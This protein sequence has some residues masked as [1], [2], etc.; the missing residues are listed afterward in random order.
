[1]GNWM[2]PATDNDLNTDSGVLLIPSDNTSAH[3]AVAHRALDMSVVRA[4]LW[5][6]LLWTLPFQLCEAVNLKCTA[7]RRGNLMIYSIDHQ[8]FP[9][10]VNLSSCY[11]SWS[12]D[13]TVLASHQDKL[14]SVKTKSL[15]NLET[16]ECFTNV[17]HKSHCASKTTG[18][19]TN[20]QAKC[21]ANCSKEGHKVTAL[22]L[23]LCEAVNLKC[24]ATRRGNLM[25]YSIDHQGFPPDVNLSSCD[26]SW[27]NDGTVLANHQDKLPSVK[28]KSLKNLETTEC[29]TN[30]VHKSHCASKTTACRTNFRANCTA[31]CREEGHKVTVPLVLGIVA[32][33]GLCMAVGGYF[34]YKSRKENHSSPR[35]PQ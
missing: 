4:V 16:T 28:T 23:Q 9:P 33:V 18:F 21:N 22:P 5:S 12:N 2:K 19:L 26:S 15:K 7:T 6:V 34:F 1:M 13:S 20:F 25:I 10:D 31:S 29:F 30:V 8:G 32:V 3:L 35:H 17:V 24:T 14:P 11:F 27:S